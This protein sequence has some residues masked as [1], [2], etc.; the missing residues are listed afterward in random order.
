MSHS[1][2]RQL[3]VF[4]SATALLA[5]ASAT[6]FAKCEVKPYAGGAL[7]TPLEETRITFSWNGRNGAPKPQEAVKAWVS[8]AASLDPHAK[9]D[10]YSGKLVDGVWSEPAVIPP[11]GR[12]IERDPFYYAGLGWVL[13]S[14]NGPE[15]MMDE[16]TSTLRIQGGGN[17]ASYG[18]LDTGD[19]VYPS[20]AP[21]GPMVF[22]GDRPDQ[23][24]DLYEATN[25]SASFYSSSDPMDYDGINTKA[26]ETTP[27]VMRMWWDGKRQSVLI[28][29]SNRKGGRGG[30]D[31][32][33]APYRTWY[34]RL[35]D[36][37]IKAEV[38]AAPK[39]FRSKINTKDDEYAP[40]L[41]PD[42]KS[43]IFVRRGSGEGANGD[44]YAA[45]WPDCAFVGQ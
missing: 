18:S 24:F 39:P 14:T 38:R 28:F 17:N 36:D 21:D 44:F 33:I 11:S 22:A 8:R 45:T 19:D 9:A 43:L 34:G 15:P 41:S 20:V 37:A 16:P 2:S 7:N 30:L 42:G 27:F 10:L 40:A 29:S 6:A 31:L 23:G 25:T 26:T 35:T 5:A 1:F 4:C 3:R 32:F 12:H 13:V